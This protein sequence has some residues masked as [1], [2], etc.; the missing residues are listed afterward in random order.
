MKNLL[1]QIALYGEMLETTERDKLGQLGSALSTIGGLLHLHTIEGDSRLSNDDIEG[2]TIAVR[3]L[4]N[5]ASCLSGDME[6]TGA[7]L[8]RM[9]QKP[10]QEGKS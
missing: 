1:R 9:C 5:Y 7:E 2:L 8:V 4:G 10:E 3:A 6:T